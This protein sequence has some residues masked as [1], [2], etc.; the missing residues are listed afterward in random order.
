MRHLHRVG[1]W[2]S[3]VAVLFAVLV[4]EVAAHGGGEEVPANLDLVLSSGG[5]T[6]SVPPGGT[7]N[8]KVRVTAPSAIAFNAALFRLVLTAEGCQVLDYHWHR[9]FVTGGVT[10][11]SLVGLTLPVTVED[12]TLEGPGYPSDT[13]DVEFGVFDLFLASSGGDLID[14][15]LRAPVDAM[16]GEI[17]FVVAYPDSFSDGFEPVAVEAGLVLTVEIANSGV[18]GDLSGDSLV[19]SQDLAILL[20]NWGGTGIGD[21]NENGSVDAKDLAVLLGAWNG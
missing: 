15:I 8:V 11:F 3:L 9:P 21:F 13:A 20:G 6:T 7:F 1:R 19:D 14:M 17:F 5:S 16:P 18:L 10:D 2:N 4:G 12:E